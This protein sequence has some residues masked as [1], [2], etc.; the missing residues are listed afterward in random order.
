MTL[1]VLTGRLLKPTSGSMR[2]SGRDVISATAR[3]MRQLRGD[4]QIIFLNPLGS[5]DSRMRVEDVIAEPLIIH[6]PM[7]APCLSSFSRKRGTTARRKRV[8]ELLRS[9]GL[10]ESAIQRYPHE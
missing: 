4:M 1:G 6:E 5:L 10:D 8:A 2:F 7:G 9:V 3:E